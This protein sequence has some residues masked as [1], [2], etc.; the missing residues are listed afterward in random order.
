M[1]TPGNVFAD[2]RQGGLLQSTKV[3]GNDLT[4]GYSLVSVIF[5]RGFRAVSHLAGSSTHA[6]HSQNQK[7]LVKNGNCPA[8][9]SAM[10]KCY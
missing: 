10:E 2:L 5:V 9:L 4:R 7:Q 3:V 1:P 8:A 6:E